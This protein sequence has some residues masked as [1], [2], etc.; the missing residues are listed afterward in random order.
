MQG[1]EIWASSL[2][3]LNNK[4]LSTGVAGACRSLLL[5]R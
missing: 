3:P 4:F 1:M 5:L 2:G